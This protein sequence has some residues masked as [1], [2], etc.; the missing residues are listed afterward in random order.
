MSE[1]MEINKTFC[2][3]FWYDMFGKHIGQLN[4]YIASDSTEKLFWS[5]SGNKGDQWMFAQTTLQASHL[6]K[7]TMQSYYSSTNS[8]FA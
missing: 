7:V 1:W 3:Q 6:F 2:L 5:Q 4:V 8:M